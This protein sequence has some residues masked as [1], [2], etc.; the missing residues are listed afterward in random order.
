MESEWQLQNAK[1]RLSRVVDL[2]AQQGPQT[3]TKHGKPAAVVLSVA[4][5]RRIKGAG[6]RLSEFF[7]KSPLH[8]AA[9]DLERSRDTGRDVRL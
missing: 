2:A 7:A 6:R 3:I 9:L 8:G 4:D 5:Y 1:N